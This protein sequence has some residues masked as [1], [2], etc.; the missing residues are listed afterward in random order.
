M[1]NIAKHSQASRVFLNLNRKNGML[2]LSVKD[3]GKGFDYQNVLSN[4]T[5]T[6][7]LGLI[8]MRERAELS[9]GR[10]ILNS[11]KDEGTL[12]QAVWQIT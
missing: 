9:F 10:F 3:N 1:N 7:G 6:Q 2:A 5:S 12:L 11:K 4:M 8:G